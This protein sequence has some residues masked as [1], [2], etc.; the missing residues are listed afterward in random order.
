MSTGDKA[1]AEGNFCCRNEWNDI[2]TAMVNLLLK[3]HEPT[4]GEIRLT[5]PILEI[6]TVMII[7]VLNV[8]PYF[9][10]AH[11]ADYSVQ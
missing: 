1:G 8:A 9:R 11:F 10:G 4:H 5:E 6:S 3:F 2:K 7:G